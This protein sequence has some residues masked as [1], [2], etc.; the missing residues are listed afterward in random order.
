MQF[1]NAIQKTE[2]LGY[3]PILSTFIILGYAAVLFNF[4]FL[5]TCL[6]GYL[7]KKTSTIPNW[8]LVFNLTLFFAELLYFI[9]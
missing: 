2:A 4:I 6:L 5:M 9:F 3:Q 7:F 8:I 1:G